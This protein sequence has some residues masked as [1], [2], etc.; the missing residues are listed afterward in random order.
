MSEWKEKWM[1]RYCAGL[2]ACLLVGAAAVAETTEY[3]AGGPLAGA[4]YDKSYAQVG[5]DVAIYPGAVEFYRANHG[6]V[7]PLFDR[8]SQIKKWV[9][10]AI[11]GAPDAPC[12]ARCRKYLDDN[13]GPAAV[14]VIDVQTIRP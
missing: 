9:A 3:E 7:K 14:V 10:P 4:K 1:A 8:Q 2:I 6:G 5:F 11:A 13:G 12:L